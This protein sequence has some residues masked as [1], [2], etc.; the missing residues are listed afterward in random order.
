M[1]TKNRLMYS[2]VCRITYSQKKAKEQF[3]TCLR[4]G[5]SPFGHKALTWPNAASVTHWGRITHICVCKLTII[6]SNNG[7]S[8]DRHQ[9]IF[10]TNAGLLSIG[11]LGTNFSEILIKIQN[12]LFT[13][14]HMKISSAKWRPF[15]SGGGGGGWVKD[16]TYFHWRIF[17]WNYRLYDWDRLGLEPL[18]VMMQSCKVLKYIHPKDAI[19]VLS[20]K[21]E[22]HKVS[23]CFTLHM[24]SLWYM[25]VQYN[26]EMSYLYNGNPC[27]WHDG[28]CFTEMGPHSILLYM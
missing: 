21:L 26:N 28:I 25:N 11:S 2:R 15:F 3:I 17:F 7:L 12:F 6:G 9:V 27:T 13:K 10:W 19:Y 24:Q 16:I 18:W 23:I 1:E 5:S 8:P 20:D 14:M 4:Y 22:T